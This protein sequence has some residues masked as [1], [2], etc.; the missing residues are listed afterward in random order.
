MPI[1]DYGPD[2][3]GYKEYVSADDIWKEPVEVPED[4]VKIWREAYYLH[5]KICQQPEYIGEI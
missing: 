1:F 5:Q 2:S 3:K 4:V